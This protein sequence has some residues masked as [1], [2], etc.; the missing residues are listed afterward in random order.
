MAVICV[1]SGTVLWST[2]RDKPLHSSTPWGRL[3]TLNHTTLAY[4]AQGQPKPKL[5]MCDVLTGE[6]KATKPIP[7]GLLPFPL[8]KRIK[9]Q[10]HPRRDL[11]YI[12]VWN[13]VFFFSTNTANCVGRLL[14]ANIP[15]TI[16]T[17]REDRPPRLCFSEYPPKYGPSHHERFFLSRN[18]PGAPDSLTYCFEYEV[19]TDNE[20]STSETRIRRMG[21]GGSEDNLIFRVQKI[22]IY[23]HSTLG[24]RK[25]PPTLNPFL[26]QSAQ[27][28]IGPV[29]GRNYTQV[30][31]HS[32][33]RNPSSSLPAS[34]Y[35]I[36]LEPKKW[37]LRRISAEFYARNGRDVF[38]TKPKRAPGHF[39]RHNERV[40]C[41]IPKPFLAP[42]VLTERYM[43]LRHQNYV[44]L[45]AYEPRW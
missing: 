15:A 18:K 20:I 7:I 16:D 38:I 5:Y 4:I 31:F 28:E 37:P 45:F 39:R 1:E 36:F 21:S 27:T 8:A 42:I 6:V 32:F 24:V 22:Q 34:T 35:N 3:V 14:V 33:R 19:P 26:K 23:Q 12:A 44:Y 10:L 30:R 43:L 29:H 9:I 2:A 11:V 17:S 25:G 40:D 41:V 13:K